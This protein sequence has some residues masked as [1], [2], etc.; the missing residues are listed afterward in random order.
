MVI[1]VVDLF[2]VAAERVKRFNIPF[3]GSQR[4]TDLPECV[5]RLKAGENKSIIFEGIAH[6]LR[7]LMGDA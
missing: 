5:E 4:Q 7:H 6:H 3:V 2:H 1:L